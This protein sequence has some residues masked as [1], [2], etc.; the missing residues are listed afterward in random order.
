[1]YSSC[2]NWVGDESCTSTPPITPVGNGPCSNCGKHCPVIIRS[3]S[4]FTIGTASSPRNWI[5]PLPPWA[6]A[7]C[8]RRRKRPR[9]NAACERLVG[10]I[11]RECLDFLI[12]LGQR[13]LK[14][15]LHCW[16]R[17]YNH[18]RVHMSLGPGI[19]APLHPSPPPSEHRHRLPRGHRVRCKAA[20]GGLHHEY[21]SEKVAA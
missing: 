19:P 18:S 9:S 14:H 2:W 20:L 11:R 5:K 12:P 10:T 7:C 13:N 4:S 21:W 8:E 15:I 17:Y 6:S 3:A 16:V 1:M